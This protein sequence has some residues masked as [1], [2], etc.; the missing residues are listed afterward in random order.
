MVKNGFYYIVY[1]FFT[2]LTAYNIMNN[3]FCEK[4]RTFSNAMGIFD[5]LI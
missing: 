4:I 5:L 3:H 2:L 1:K